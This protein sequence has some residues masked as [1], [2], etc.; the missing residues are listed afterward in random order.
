MASSQCTCT[1]PPATVTSPTDICRHRS[2]RWTPGWPP[3][4]RS[5]R[6]QEDQ[7][8]REHLAVEQASE[9]YIAELRRRC[10]E[11]VEAERHLYTECV[12]GKTE[13]TD[14][15]SDEG[16]DGDDGNYGPSPMAG[17]LSRAE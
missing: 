9:A 12:V 6:R 15:S 4:T 11:C 1:A 16:G 13:V 8:A 14:L 5:E 3:H 10:P 2:H 7:E 17:G